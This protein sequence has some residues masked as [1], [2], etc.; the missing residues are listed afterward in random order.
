QA[1][2]VTP[3]NAIQKIESYIQSTILE[4]MQLWLIAPGSWHA[5]TYLPG[6]MDQEIHKEV[7]T[8]ET[9]RAHLK[10]AI[11]LA[12]VIIALMNRTSLPINPDCFG[13]SIKKSKTK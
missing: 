6:G 7:L 3:G 5:L 9:A 8:F 10:K 2:V 13:A 12:L 4:A 11:V 1:D